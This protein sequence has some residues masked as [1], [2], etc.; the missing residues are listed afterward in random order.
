[1]Q[2]RLAKVLS[3]STAILLLLSV[4]VVTGFTSTESEETDYVLVEIQGMNDMNKLSEMGANIVHRYPDYA[5]VETDDV[6]ALE[7]ADLEVNSLAGRTTVSVKGH[8]FDI[9]DGLPTFSE[10]LTIDGY[11]S[12]ERGLYLVHLLGPVAPEWRAT[13]ENMDLDILDYA[14]TYAYEV[15]MTPEMAEEVKDLN[16]VEWVGIYQPGFKLAE[17]L[18]TG[19]VSVEMA[20][21]SR[22]IIDVTDGSAFVELARNPDVYYISNYLEPQL[23]GEVSTQTIGGGN[24]VWDPDDDPYVPWRGHD[25]EF[26]Y[27]AHVNH[28]GYEGDGVTV[29]V[30]DTGILSDH[31]DFQDRVI[32]GYDFTGSGTWEDGHGHGTHCAGSVAGHTYAGTGD[33]VDDHWSTDVEDYYVAQ[34]MAPQSEL[35]SVRIFDDGGG[36]HVPSDSTQVVTVARDNS[37]AYIHTNSWGSDSRGSYGDTDSDYD[38][39]VRDAGDGEPMVITVSAG[40]EG[41]GPDYETTGSPGNAKNVITVGASES[42]YPGLTDQVDD[43]EADPDRTATF[44]S[45]GWTEDGRVKPDVMAPGWIVFSTYVDE[46]T[47]EW[48]YA[49]LGG[50]SMSNPAVAG[51]AAV[52]TEWYE[53]LYGVRPSPALV[54]AMMINT[55]YDMEDQPGDY[56]TGPI[57]NRDEGWGLVNLPMLMDAPVDI[58]LE[59][60][61]TVLETQEEHSYEIQYQDDDEP[62]KISVVWTDAPASSGADPTLRNNLNIEVETPGGEVIRGNAFDLS[63]DGES[64]DGYTYPDAEVL[65]N[66]DGSGDG[67]DDRNNVLNVFIPES[68]LEQGTYTVTVRAEDVP[69][70]VVENGQDYALVMFNAE[71]PVTEEPPEISITRPSGGETWDAHDMQDIEWTTTAGDGTIT[72]I[73]L[74]YTTDD[75]ASW[76]EII[77]DTADTGSYTWEVP[78]IETDEARIRATVD[79]D[80]D[81]SDTDVSNIFNIDGTTPPGII[82][83]SPDEGEVWNA[84]NDESITWDSSPGDGAVTGVDLEY[85][86]NDGED[87]DLIVSGTSDTGE[88][89]W[90]VPDEGTDE[91]RIR[92]TINDDNDLSGSDVSPLFTIWG[93][94]PEPPENLVVEHEGLGDGVLFEDDVSEDKGYTTGTSEDG[95]EFEILQH[96]SVVGDNSWDFGDGE[97]YKTGDYGYTSEL[98]TPEISIP[99]DVDSVELSFQHWRSFADDS[100]YDGGNLKISTDGI[101]GT[102]ELLE[103]EEGYDGEIDAGF[104]NPLGGELG[105]GYEVGWETVTV[106]LTEYEGS[107]IHLMWIAGV[108]AWDGFYGDGWRIDDIS[109]TAEGVPSDGDEHNLITW[110]ASPDDPDEVSHYN[111]YRSE[112]QNGPWDETTLIDSVN[113]DGSPSYEYLD[114]DRGMADEIFWWYVVRAVDEHGQSDGNEDAVQEPGDDALPTMDI[115]LTSDEDGWNFVS[116]NLELSNTDL[117]DILE[118]PEYGI[119]GNYDSV[120]YYDAGNWYSYVPGRADHFNNLGTWDHTMGIWIRMNVDDTLTVEGNEPGTTTITLDPGWNMV[121]LPSSSTGNHD[122]PAE[123]TTVGHFDPAQEYNIAYVDAAGYEFSPGEAYWLYND[124]D[125]TVDWTVEY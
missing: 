4:F 110:D 121:G 37:D 82:L 26:E 20:D 18:R 19:P 35:Y 8:V 39:V 87:W 13:L 103:P 49:G 71:D 53:D 28:L 88:Y 3:I 24:W 41:E 60:E 17:D 21:G 48:S 69:D 123:V 34:G 2:K 111:L 57:P 9:N 86:T 113:A 31:P 91:A 120:M 30:A 43:Y 124:A 65:P 32:G 83:T 42:F 70:P 101:G 1:M 29:A 23:H 98:I 72:G 7:S 73:D 76:T 104:G 122:L 14:P 68:D 92:A 90:N 63:G 74:E 95:T 40:N 115:P 112:E 5:L 96:G 125:H 54:K 100:M 78:D 50:T 12:G 114:E 52:V 51:G 36:S 64:D 93:T 15:R 108:E 56:Y 6:D 97:Y 44:S 67:W 105:W 99:N 94:P 10:E 106:D 81:L 47:G 66:F 62:L 79:D 85:S 109:V 75:G 45:R 25:D 33:S 89:L 59:D 16:F 116:F 119:A 117:V 80:N 102:F 11:E 107:S 55:A 58:M 118:D 77:A 46:D 84:G 38:S 22:R 61:A 27:G